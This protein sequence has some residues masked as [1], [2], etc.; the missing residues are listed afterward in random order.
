MTTDID[1]KKELNLTQNTLY[2][3]STFSQICTRAASEK[4][5]E[6]VSISEKT[7]NDIAIKMHDI[8]IATNSFGKSYS[9]YEKSFFTLTHQTPYRNLKQI[10]AEIEKKRNALKESEYKSKL[11]MVNLMEIEV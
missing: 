6:L 11:N 7:L 2:N 3:G 5:T 9:Q 4:T 1:I 8:N 10:L